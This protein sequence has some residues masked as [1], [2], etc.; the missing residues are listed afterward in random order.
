[1]SQVITERFVD[2]NANRVQCGIVYCFSRNDC[3]KVAQ[4][5]RGTF[6]KPGKPR[7]NIR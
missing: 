5:L 4:E 1:M 2:K 7:L 3:G 6:N